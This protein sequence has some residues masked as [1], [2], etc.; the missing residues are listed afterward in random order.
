MRLVSVEEAYQLALC[1][2]QPT[3]GS[4]ARRSVQNWNNMAQRGNTTFTNRNASGG[5]DRYTSRPATNQE[6]GEPDREDKR[7]K[8]VMGGRYDKGKGECFKCGG[9]G[10]FAVVCPTRDQKLTL[11]CGDTTHIA[12]HAGTDVPLPESSDN[13]EEFPK[14]C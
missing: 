4:P 10:H 7:G 14:K 11:V 5:S 6:H 9:R 8:V 1:L 12:E 3:R 13:E 2:E